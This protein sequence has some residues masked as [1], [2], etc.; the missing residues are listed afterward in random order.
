M[1]RGSYIS[2]Q[3]ALAHYGLIPEGTPVVTSDTTTR[4][5]AWKTPLGDFD[6]RR[7]KVELFFGYQ[8]VDVAPGQGA[9]IATPKKALLDLIYL[10]PGGD[11]IDTNPHPRRP[12]I[13]MPGGWR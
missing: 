3:S 9:F 12:V 4:P 11:D 2:L 5:G 6:F 8:L 1:V 10:Q 7:I 13:R